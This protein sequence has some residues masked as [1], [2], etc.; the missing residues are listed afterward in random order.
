MKTN[1]AFTKRVK[2]TKSGKLLA[3]HGGKNH[4]NAKES[5]NK[6]MASNRPMEI[7]MSRKSKSRFL[8]NQ[9]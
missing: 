9:I 2:V 6:Q 5:R 3:R 8:V 1:K 4:F 7:T